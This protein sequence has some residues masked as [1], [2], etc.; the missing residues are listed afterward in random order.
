MLH[1]NAGSIAAHSVWVHDAILASTMV[2]HSVT[3]EAI[4]H[5]E[6]ATLQVHRH[7]KL[8]WARVF[9]VLQALD[10]RQPQGW[11]MIEHGAS[12]YGIKGNV[13]QMLQHNLHRHATWTDHM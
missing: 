9:P 13:L 11:Q 3:P 6:P 5:Q 4:L 7:C 10:P 12:N 1:V 2:G 8:H